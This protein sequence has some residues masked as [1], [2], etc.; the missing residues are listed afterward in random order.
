MVLVSFR[1]LG[2]QEAGE[3]L[4]WAGLEEDV[5]VFAEDSPNVCRRGLA[6]VR[7]GFGA[8][9]GAILLAIEQIEDGARSAGDPLEIAD[10]TGVDVDS[11]GADEPTLHR[12]DAHPRLLEADG[13]A[14]DPAE[15]VG[16][17]NVADDRR[18]GSE[19][20]HGSSPVA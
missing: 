1:L 17:A 13:P 15:Q 8:V 3:A 7:R 19:G 10:G 16:V 20:N 11:A 6:P 2:G 12:A 18:R 4:A 14:T 9:E 5:D